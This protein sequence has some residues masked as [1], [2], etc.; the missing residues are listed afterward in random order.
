MHSPM[1]FPLP[2]L[3]WF[4]RRRVSLSPASNV[5][6]AEKLTDDRRNSSS[7]AITYTSSDSYTLVDPSEGVDEESCESISE[8]STVSKPPCDQ[9]VSEALSP[10]DVIYNQWRD[11][12]ESANKEQRDEYL[13]RSTWQYGDICKRFESR[14]AQEVRPDSCIVRGH[15][16]SLDTS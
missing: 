13:R 9:K 11:V 6:I 12:M 16:L 2:F 7:T 8:C 5:L 4:R 3:S 15:V 14:Y 1:Y 10:Y